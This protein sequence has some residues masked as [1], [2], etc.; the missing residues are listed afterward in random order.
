MKDSEDPG[1]SSEFQDTLLLGRRTVLTYI[2]L[3]TVEPVRLRAQV[4][5]QA[6]CTR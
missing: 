2:T 4:C 3:E 6:L 5:P 1:R